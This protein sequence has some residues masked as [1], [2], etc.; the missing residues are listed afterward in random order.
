MNKSRPKLRKRSPKGLAELKVYLDRINDSVEKP[1]YIQSDPVQFIHAFENKKDIEIAGFFAALMAW[2]RR[3]I[4]I[5]KVENLLQRMNYKPFEF[6]TRYSQDDFSSLT[7]F[8]HRTF[9]PIDI[10][11]LICVLQIIYKEYED[12]EEFWSECYHTGKIEDR[13]ALSILNEKLFCL[14]PELNNRTHKHLSNPEHGSTCKRLCMYLRW[15]IRKNS[16]VDIGIWDFMESSELQI[17]FD[18]HVAR[19]A[20][21]Y[22]LVSRRSN[23]WKT[24]N[25]LTDT[26][27]LMNPDDPVRYDFALFGI[28]ALDLTLPKRFLLNK[29]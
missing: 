21:R 6:V 20:R 12:L 3:D 17:P 4:V 16:A 18:V 24:V 23:D 14:T 10:H 19:Q 13:P 9:K 29:I 1:E 8:K 27:K 26:L 28:G 22:G 11:G 2:G 7:G 15:M 5:K 25:E